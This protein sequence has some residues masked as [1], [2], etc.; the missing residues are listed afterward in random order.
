MFRKKIIY[1]SSN[2]KRSLHLGTKVKS[3]GCLD[4]GT[5]GVFH[6]VPWFSGRMKF[7][8]VTV[9]MV[10]EDVMISYNSP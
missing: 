6:D 7:N 8:G 9:T 1:T 3:N 10:N 4:I 2:L 5:E